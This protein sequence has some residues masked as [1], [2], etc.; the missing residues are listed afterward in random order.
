MGIALE[1]VWSVQMKFNALLAQRL[2]PIFQP[3]RNRS[4]GPSR[5]ALSTHE[6]EVVPFQC[7]ERPNSVYYNTPNLVGFFSG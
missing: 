3:L 4:S 2:C 5:V 7:R 6:S 1:K